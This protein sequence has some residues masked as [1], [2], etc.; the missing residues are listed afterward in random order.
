[1]YPFILSILLALQLV[2]SNFGPAERCIL[3]QN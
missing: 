2:I 1:M 3:V